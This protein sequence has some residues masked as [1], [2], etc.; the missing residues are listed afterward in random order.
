M[1][2]ISLESFICKSLAHENKHSPESLMSSQR[3]PGKQGSQSRLWQCHILQIVR[4]NDRSQKPGVAQLSEFANR[5]FTCFKGVS[6]ISIAKDVSEIF[7]TSTVWRQFFFRQ[8]CFH[9]L[10]AKEK[11][12]YRCEFLLLVI[13]YDRKNDHNQ[14]KFWGA[15][16]WAQI[17]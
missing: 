8:F 3:S 15:A 13:K 14:I 9:L 11:D 4:F 12:F 7:S 5:C 2:I 1:T 10:K 16:P 6:R 17:E